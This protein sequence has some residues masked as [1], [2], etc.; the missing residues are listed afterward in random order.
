MNTSDSR[1]SRLRWPWA[2]GVVVSLGLLMHC[3]FAG[4]RTVSDPAGS[5]PFDATQP[6]KL[7]FGRGSGWHGLDTVAI[8]QDGQTSLHRS[9]RNGSWERSSLRL[10]AEQI[11]AVARAV[12][13]HGLPR[14]AKEYHTDIAD[15]TQ[16]VLW[17]R[18]GQ[19]QKA[20]YFNNN[21]PD[22]IRHFARQLDGVLRSAGYDALRW[23]PVKSRD[24]EK[25]L[26][27]SIK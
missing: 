10:S 27:N 6:F 24:H 1:G 21:F 18:Q 9:R 25:E 22:S 2:L 17:I 19:R 15:G 23:Q 26:W 4:E 20:T 8:A 14:L 3:A 16:W 11:R 5:L 7:D 12:A 13:R